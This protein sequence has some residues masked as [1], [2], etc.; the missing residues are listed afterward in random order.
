[1]MR[2][3]D[4]RVIRSAAK[5]F[6]MVAVFVMTAVTCLAYLNT[7][8]VNADSEVTISAV[9]TKT[10]VGPGDLLTINVVA[11]SFP[12]V[13]EFGPIVF[14]FDFDKAEYVS[15]EQGKDLSNY[16][17]TETQ[18]DGVVTVTGSDQMM[19]ISTDGSGDEVT[20]AS[21]ESEDRVILFTIMIR[22][23]PEA[24]GDINCWIS[25]VGDFSSPNESVSAK[26][27]SGVT[28]PINKSG[29]SSDA[30][31][32]ILKVRE[33]A[34]TPEFNQNIT[35]YTCYVERSVEEV[36]IS[37]TTT[38]LWAAVVIEGTQQLKIGE[39][40]VT[41]D[42]TAQDGVSHM[43]YTIHVIRK[44]SDIPDNASLID[45]N[46][47]TYT[48]L[49]SPEDLNVPDGFVQTTV[50]INGYSVPAYVKD[51]VSSVLIYL[52]DGT[53]S[54]GLYFYN[55]T[56]KTILPY[57]PENTIIE[58]SKVLKM[59]EV[60]EGVFIPDEFRPSSFNYGSMV[61]TGYSNAEGDFICYLQD[62]NGKAD[63]YY[64]NFTD[65]SISLYRFADKKA[66]ILYSYLFDVFL[67]I[68]IIE[69][70]IITITVYIVRR[71]VSGRTNPR[72]KRV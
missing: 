64:F 25:E 33:S 37:V 32:A 30:T 46:G 8:K 26:I 42:V 50:Y 58:T 16:L 71:M 27:G 10:D 65:G 43:R 11:S 41:V 28:L 56:T 3:P 19:G 72:P 6:V 34:I 57:D 44:E 69:A 66:E 9:S 60:P 62:E 14:N 59:A 39:N 67:V 48:F 47:I 36:Q 18:T 23:R 40:I 15:Y 35:D 53:Q 17:F 54:P 61:L 63:F 22:I 49:D 7:S 2:K 45:K 12:G 68:A 70:V 21:F 52:F 1:M 51:G 24:S 29:I 55:S 13:T 4:R 20:T 31:V 38:N 5:V